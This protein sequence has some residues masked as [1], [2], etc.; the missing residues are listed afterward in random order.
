VAGEWA[1]MF[2][3]LVAAHWRWGIG[4]LLKEGPGN[5]HEVEVGGERQ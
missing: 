4:M 5:Q 1:A 3:A 2:G